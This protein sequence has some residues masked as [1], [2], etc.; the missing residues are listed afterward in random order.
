M[1]VKD[2]AFEE[3]RIIDDLLQRLQA[4]R[5]CL[6]EM[7]VKVVEAELDCICAHFPIL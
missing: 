7:E 3:L 4:A 6:K 5:G 1:R 2:Q